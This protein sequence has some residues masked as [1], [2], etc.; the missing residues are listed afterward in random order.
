MPVKNKID[1]WTEVLT[2]ITDPLNKQ[3]TPIRVRKVLR[4]IIDSYA[5]VESTKDNITAFTAGGQTNATIIKDS[6]NIVENASALNSSIKLLIAVK[7]GKVEVTNQSLN[8][9]MI[10][11]A[12]GQRF[13]NKSTLMGINAGFQIRTGNTF[14]FRCYSTGI[15]RF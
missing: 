11:P 4:D 7:N 6:I 8:H 1:L 5:D 14:L 10:F 13:K 3:N 2:N 12:T 9:I 15:W